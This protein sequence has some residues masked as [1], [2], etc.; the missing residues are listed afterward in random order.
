MLRVP[1][2]FV[3]VFWQRREIKSLCHPPDGLALAAILL[4]VGI[5]VVVANAVFQDFRNGRAGPGAELR[6]VLDAEDIIVSDTTIEDYEA[7]A[8]FDVLAQL[9]IRNNSF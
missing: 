3:A 7:V 5:N 6:P 2:D 8:M 1:F 9:F 4:L